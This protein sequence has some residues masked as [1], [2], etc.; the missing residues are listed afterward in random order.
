MIRVAVVGQL[1]GKLP[2]HV[3][4]QAEILSTLLRK[5]G[6]PVISISSLSSRYLRLAEIIKTLITRNGE[7]DL[8]C[9]QVF[10]GPGF[11][12]ADVASMI[13]KL[14]GQPIVMVLR[15]GA[16]PEFIARFPRWVCR[17]LGRADTLIAPSKFLAREMVPYGFQPQVISNVI[18]ISNYP[19]R[20]RQVIGPRLLWMRSFHPVYNPSMAVRVLAQLRSTVPEASLVMCGQDKGLEAEVK[21]LAKTLGV[22]GAVRFAGFL[23]M[24]DK[25]REGQ[26]ADIFLNTNHVD[27]MPV[28]V[29]EACAMGLPVVATTVGGIPDLLTN[30]ETGLLVPDGDEQAMVKAVIRLL[31]DSSLTKRLSSNGRRLATHSSW[32]QILPQWKRVFAEVMDRRMKVRGKD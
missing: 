2:G 13:G 31:E 30:E 23:N 15:G 8:Q 20:H 7:I 27:N 14:L 28:S 4:T 22:D 24:A 16:L 26:W 12:I 25:A 3:T 32:E 29:V 10:S 21:R 18:D 9:L 19:Y 5:E 17:V 6:F 1:V 11:L